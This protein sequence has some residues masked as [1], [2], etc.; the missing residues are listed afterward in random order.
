M[1][2]GAYESG[3]RLPLAEKDI[4]ID[5]Q[6]GVA[7]WCLPEHKELEVE[8][9]K[10]IRK[11]QDTPKILLR[12]K[13]VSERVRGPLSPLHGELHDT[14]QHLIDRYPSRF[15]GLTAWLCC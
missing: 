15:I 4:I 14:S 7:L 5:R 12:I 10:L 3:F 6:N 13:T 11:V 8:V 9:V 2:D 1:G